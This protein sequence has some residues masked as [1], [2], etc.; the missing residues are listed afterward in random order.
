MKKYEFTVFG[1]ATTVKVFK[2]KEF[3]RPGM[4]TPILN[5]NFDK[6]YYG[7]K[8]WNIAY[9][10]VKLGVPVYPVLAYSDDRFYEEIERVNKEFG[11]PVDA[12]VK[13]PKGEYDY[14]T[15]YMLE[16]ERKN[17][18]T[19]G[20]YYS[21]EGSV[22]LGK[23]TA[24]HIP[25][26]PEFLDKSKMAVLTCPK[27]GDLQPMYEAIKASGL[28]MVLCMSLDAAVFNKENL[29]PILKDATIIFANEVEIKWIEDL[30][31]YTDITEMFQIGK[32]EIIVKTMG[33]RGSIIFEKKGGRAVE[34]TVPITKAKV[35]DINAIGAG[36]AY[37]SGFLY[38]LSQ[39]RDPV[40]AAQYGST[41]ASFIIEDYGS[42]T[43]SPSEEELLERNSERE[44]A[45]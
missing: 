2:F 30:Y 15:C 11:T 7:G 44:D 17:H 3:P 33:E 20:G 28:P 42:A 5:D 39:G 14:L 43:R 31:G 36:D 40:T 38:G 13:S 23:L 21:S 4:T 12:V 27:A 24:D 22:D 16:D 32:A 19:I 34:T 10:L 29:E 26:K 35:E 6:L 25:M 45:H 8:A 18:I 9:N 37:V 41:E 1:T